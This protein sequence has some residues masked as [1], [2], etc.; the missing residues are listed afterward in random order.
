MFRGAGLE[1]SDI[2][3]EAAVIEKK[4]VS[5]AEREAI[6]KELDRLGMEYEMV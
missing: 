6:I 4:G 5:S 2:E 3:I 1:R